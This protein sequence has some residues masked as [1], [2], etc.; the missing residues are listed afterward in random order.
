MDWTKIWLCVPTRSNI[1]D[2]C[3]GKGQQQITTLLSAQDH[4]TENLPVSEKYDHGSYWPWNQECAGK[5]QQQIVRPDQD[6]SSLSPASE[7]RSR[8]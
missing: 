2:D 7:D 8:W 1:K 5:G 3:A 6:H 4:E